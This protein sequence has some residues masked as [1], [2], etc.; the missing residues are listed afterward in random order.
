MAANNSTVVIVPG[1]WQLRS[2]WEGFMSILRA[3]G[4]PTRYVD[5]PT[6]GGTNLPLA[7]LADDVAAVRDTLNGLLSEGK[8]VT[9]LCHSAGGLVASNA[10]EGL[11][12]ASR[13]A[14]G[15]KGGVCQILFMSAFMIPTG[16]SLIDM[17]G[18]E[19]LPWMKLMDDR[20]VGNPD[21]LPQVAFNDLEEV[22]QRIW[23]KEMTHSAMGLFTT[24]SSFEPWSNSIPIAYIFCTED[25]ALPYPV[26]QQMSLQAGPDLAFVN[27]R[28]SHCPF[29]SVPYRL[30][31]AMETMMVLAN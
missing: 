10:V 28:A 2:G 15:L 31:E 18:G 3:A 9:I 21:M 24:P 19:P 7:G 17:L 20:V 12:T 11:D 29:L 26:Q 5:P 14:D 6:L 30:F 25:N 8:Q 27:L 22:A 13:L 16:K 1:A 23:S 4:Y